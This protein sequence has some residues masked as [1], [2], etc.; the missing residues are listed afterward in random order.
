MEPMKSIINILTFGS[1]QQQQEE[2]EEKAN[3]WKLDQIL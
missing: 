2:E 1:E 3:S